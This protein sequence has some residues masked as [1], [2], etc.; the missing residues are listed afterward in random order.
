MKNNE[1]IEKFREFIE[2]YCSV[3]RQN[4]AKNEVVK[5]ITKNIPELLNDI[6]DI[7]NNKFH[8][9]GSCGNGNPAEVPWLSI[10]M[11]NI[12]TKAT[13]GVY[14]VF[15]IKADLSGM[16]LS[17]NQGFT[18]FM[19]K[20]GKKEGMKKIKIASEEIRNILSGV[21]NNSIFNI[22]LCCTN[23]LGKGYESGNIFA[24]YYD[25]N[26]MPDDL[27]LIKDVKEFIIIYN[28][29]KNIIG[30]RSVE[31]F[32]DYI[33][34]KNDG[35]ELEEKDQ[36]KRINEVL[37]VSE[38]QEEYFV[39][40]KGIKKE[41]KETI[42]NNKGKKVYPRDIDTA[43]NSLKI[44]DYKCEIDESHPTFTRKSNNEKYTEAHHLIPI[45]YQDYFDYS[46]DVE[47]NICSLCSNCH[48]CLHYGIDE[49]RFVLLRKLYEK[50]KEHLKNV[51]LDITLDQ[52]IEF[53]N[54]NIYK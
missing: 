35:Y 54:I 12:T 9:K 48:N 26:N 36:I 45:K 53:Y 47:E 15:L 5:I 10:F 8:I 22:D 24:R 37:A 52:L 4:F 27:E 11:R 16:Y 33:L 13:K 32:Y 7:D 20:Y 21:P 6:L 30:S 17:L 19:D 43:A 14:I 51:G 41:K 44:A 50:R 34:L 25:V 2:N 3:N 1:I 49:E 31:Q 23:H 29:L 46:L 40:F 18:Y 39:E 42:I 28:E 38:P